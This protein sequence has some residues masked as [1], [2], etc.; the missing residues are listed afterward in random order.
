M[1]PLFPKQ[2]LYTDI[3]PHRAFMPAV[4]RLALRDGAKFSTAKLDA[5]II[6]IQAHGLTAHGAVDL[7][8]I[9]P[10]S[11]YCRSER[12]MLDLVR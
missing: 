7:D 3:R 12:R 6:F 11:I 8:R 9:N 1:R 10:D 4:K 5:F 2:R